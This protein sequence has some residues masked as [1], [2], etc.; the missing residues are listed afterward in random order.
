MNGRNRMFVDAFLF[1]GYMESNW[2]C[3]ARSGYPTDCVDVM[4][5]L[6]SSVAL[7]CSLTFGLASACRLGSNSVLTCPDNLSIS[8]DVRQV[9]HF[10]AEPTSVAPDTGSSD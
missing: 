6:P 3:S 4:D 7:D 1:E 2:I 8:T 5:M 9:V 10:A